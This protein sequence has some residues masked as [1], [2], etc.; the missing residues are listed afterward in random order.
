MNPNLNIR[1]LYKEYEIICEFKNRKVLS[2]WKFRH[3]FNTEFNLEFHPKSVDSCKTCDEFRTL[4]QSDATKKKEKLSVKRE[5][6][7]QLVKRTKEIFDDTVKQARN[8]SSKT[9]VL[10]FDLQRALEIPSISTSEA[11]Y[12]R[13]LWCYNL[14]IYDEKRNMGYMYF[15]D[16]S[17]A[18]RGS[19]EISSCLKKHFENYIPKDTEKIILYSDACGGQNRNIKTT[20]MIK[21]MLNSWPYR[22]LKLIDQRFFVSGHSYNSCDRC[23]GIIERQKKLTES[24]FVPQHWMNIIKQA[25]KSKPTFEVIQMKKEDFFSCKQIESIITNR[26]KSL[27]KD[28][29]E[30]LKIQRIVNHRSKPF[31]ITVYS[32]DFNQPIEVSLRK[33]GKIAKS[34]TFDRVNFQSLINLYQQSRPIQQKKYNDL[35]KL[36]KFVPSQYHWFYKELKCED[37]KN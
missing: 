31:N 17:V 3:I 1:R 37:D 27:Q 15:W 7:L 32:N 4:M 8:D 19:Q 14:C 22:E 9:E 12:R 28:K 30:W 11:F 33:N 13:Q 21:K 6:H 16:E 36:L 2:E 20:L 10:V 23:F 5:Q 25:K 34:L 35:M 29:V 24:I 26:K 18:L